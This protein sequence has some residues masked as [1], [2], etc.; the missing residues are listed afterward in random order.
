MSGDKLLIGQLN[1]ELPENVAIKW[2]SLG[3]GG[4]L[5]YTCCFRVLP[6]KCAAIISL[7]YGME[8]AHHRSAMN[9]QRWIE[10]NHT[11]NFQY[12]YVF[13]VILIS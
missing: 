8:Y 11:H 6:S 9:I 13:I 1:G 2:G 7:Y 5:I 12:L 3:V 10:S 4:V